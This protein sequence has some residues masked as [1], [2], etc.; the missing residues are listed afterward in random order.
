MGYIPLAR[1]RQSTQRYGV[2][3]PL[4]IAHSTQ[5]R[6]PSSCGI[7]KPN[8]SLCLS[9]SLL[10]LSVSLCLSSLSL[11]LSLSLSVSLSLCLS[12]V[13]SVSLSVS[14]THPGQEALDA[15][16]RYQDPVHLHSLSE[17]R[18][19]RRDEQPGLEA[20]QLERPRHLERHRALRPRPAGTGREYH[21]ARGRGWGQILGCPGA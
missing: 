8:N 21:P 5:V 4:D 10:S 15:R 17:A 7:V 14:P 20:A 12:L 19:V 13:L 2:F 3:G 9:L 16:L 1:K 18:H 6:T 11:S